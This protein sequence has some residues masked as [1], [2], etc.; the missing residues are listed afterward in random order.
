MKIKYLSIVFT[1][2]LSSL[3]YAQNKQNA[4]VNQYVVGFYNLENLFDTIHD[5]GKNDYEYLPNGANHWNTMR[6]TNKQKKMAYA[7]SKMPANLAVLGVSEIENRHVLEDLVAQPA[8]K[9]RHLQIV[10]YEGPDSRGVDVGLLYNPAVFK[11]LNTSSHRLKTEIPDFITRDQLVVTG[12]LD[13]EEINVIVL[14]WPSKYGGEAR[15]VP[16]RR[17]AALTTKFLVDSLFQLNPKAKTIVMGD[18]NDDP[19][20]PSL[21]VHLNAKPTKRATQPLQ[22]YNPYYELYKQGIGS[23][24]YNDQ[25]NLFDQ[26]IISYELLPKNL[27]DY[28]TLKFI[29]AEVFNKDF[30]KQETGKHRGYPLRTHLG[31]VWQNGYSDH[32]P[33]LIWLGKYAKN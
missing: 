31:G 5:E 6:Y 14:H 27:D 12:L 10:H 9:D 18:L 26:I 32:F 8:I 21:M 22:L 33:S 11:V 15:S 7:I 28:K 17:D 4:Q 1:L 16:R 3:A 24:G 29:R 23:L 13:G 20:E 2:F 19:I 25:W 30:L